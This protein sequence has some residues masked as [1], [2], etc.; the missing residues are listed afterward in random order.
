MDDRHQSDSS[1]LPRSLEFVQVSCPWALLLIL[2]FFLSRWPMR[3]HTAYCK[4]RRRRQSEGPSGCSLPAGRLY[5]YLAVASMGVIP[6]FVFCFLVCFV[7]FLFFFSNGHDV[8]IRWS[9]F[10]VFVF[11]FP[12]SFKVGNQENPRMF[13]FVLAHKAEFFV[14]VA[15]MRFLSLMQ[16]LASISRFK[17]R[18]MRRFDSSSEILAWTPAMQNAVPN[19]LS[20]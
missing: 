15:T 4:E 7:L 20:S 14:V 5:D 16:G 3:I 10:I 13:Q 9:I 17:L 19:S 2:L 18:D 6:F 11:P 8:V 12:F 1:M